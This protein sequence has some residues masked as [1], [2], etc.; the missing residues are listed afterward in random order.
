[1]EMDG[2]SCK[3]LCHLTLPNSWSKYEYQPQCLGPSLK[4]SLPSFRLEE[5]LTRMWCHEFHSFALELN[6]KHFNLLIFY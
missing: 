2:S 1:M 6:G 4:I 5:S 3:P